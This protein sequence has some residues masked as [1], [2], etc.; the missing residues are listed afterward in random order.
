MQHHEELAAQV[1]GQCRGHVLGR[2][3]RV[4]V[5]FD[6]QLVPVAHEHC[7]DVVHKVGDSKHDVGAGQPVPV[8]KEAQRRKRGWN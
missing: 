5:T 1:A 7:V 6:L 3:R 8:G 2:G 4:L